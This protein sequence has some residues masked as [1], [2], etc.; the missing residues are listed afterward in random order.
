MADAD[1]TPMRIRLADHRKE[2]I[3]QAFEGFYSEAFDERL[4]RY[5]AEQVLAFFV[6]TLGPSIYNQA[7]QDAR[8]FVLGKLEDLDAEFYEPERTSGASGPEPRAGG[9]DS[10]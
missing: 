1:P 7:I 4:S 9:Q 8:R 3:L 5:R 2:A 10:Q 6:R